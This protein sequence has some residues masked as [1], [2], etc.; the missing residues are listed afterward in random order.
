MLVNRAIYDDDHAQLRDSLRRFAAEEIAPHFDAWE[1]AGMVDRA[2]WARMGEA[3]I[4]CPTVPEEYDG[5]GA[6]FR[7]HTVVAEELA[8]SGFMGPAADVSVH[9]DVCLGYLLKHATPE[10]KARWLPGMVDGSLVCAIAMTEPG[11][12]SDLQGVRTRA[13]R[14]DAGWCLDGVKV[15]VPAAHLA[16]A[17]LVPTGGGGLLAGVAIALSHRNPSTR[18]IAVEPTDANAMALSVEAGEPVTLDKVPGT[19]ADGLKPM[20]P[21]E[22]T[23]EAA[24]KHVDRVLLVD[25]DSILR[26]Q[27]LLLERAKLLVEPSGAAGVAA[28]LGSHELAGLRVVTILTGGNTDLA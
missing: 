26:A 18:V 27:R 28:L 5:L 4:L 6:D 10:Q 11:T 16:D 15:C 14:D 17:I 22:L 23:L 7:M 12:G 8:Y 20:A 1:S 3:G 9:S 24:I 21:G 2:L 25:D 13:R 19:I